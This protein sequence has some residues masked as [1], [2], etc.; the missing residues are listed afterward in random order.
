MWCYYAYLCKQKCPFLLHSSKGWKKTISIVDSQ[1]TEVLGKEKV[2]LK[3]T[4]GK[5][6]S[7]GEE[8]HIPNITT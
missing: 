2:L 1:T 8:L 7:L 6:L 5:T 4:S 3:L